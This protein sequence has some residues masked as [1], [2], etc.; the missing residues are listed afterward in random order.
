MG[1]KLFLPSCP[2]NWETPST[3]YCTPAFS[4][5]QIYVKAGRFCRKGTLLEVV[6]LPHRARDNT[7]N[8]AQTP[9]TTPHQPSQEPAPECFGDLEH[10]IWQAVPQSSYPFLAGSKGPWVS[11]ENIHR[12]SY[13]CGRVS[14]GGNRSQAK[15]V[16]FGCLRYSEICHRT[17]P[18]QIGSGTSSRKC[19]TC[20]SF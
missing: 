8:F 19:P 17:R 15:P 13:V 2:S 5:C 3:F 11:R 20:Y 16:L 9:Q 4:F 1:G 14:N 10:L 7:K 6:P 18:A 12:F